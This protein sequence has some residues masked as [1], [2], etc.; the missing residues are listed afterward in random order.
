MILDKS[1]FMYFL[2]STF[3]YIPKFVWNVDFL[4]YEIVHATLGSRALETLGLSV[5]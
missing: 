2:K 3:M 1:T 4:K 5:L